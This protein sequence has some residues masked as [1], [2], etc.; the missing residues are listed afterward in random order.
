[1]K[2]FWPKHKKSTNIVTNSEE[3]TTGK[4]H[5]K[6]QGLMRLVHCD[7]PKTTEYCMYTSIINTIFVCHWHGF[8]IRDWRPLHRTHFRID[9][10]FV[11]LLLF[12]CFCSSR[13]LQLIRLPFFHLRFICCTRFSICGKY[14]SIAHKF[15]S[16]YSKL[17]SLYLAY[18]SH[19]PIWVLLFS[20][21]AAAA[22]SLSW[23]LHSKTRSHLVRARSHC[24]RYEGRGGTKK[25]QP[26]KQRIIKSHRFQT[27]SPMPNINGK[28]TFVG[29]VLWVS[30]CGGA[31][32]PCI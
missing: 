31:Q 15:T 24:R 3:K 16:N 28:I 8:G 10:F 17:T 9:R 26:T 7:I 21:S 25:N 1:M 20:R 29:G 22:A 30:L 18:V 5:S 23:N 13:A 32:L 6:H 2:I 27:K 14:H 4:C 12:F 11:L 19:L